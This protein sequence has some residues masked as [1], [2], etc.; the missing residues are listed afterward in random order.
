M[1]VAGEDVRLVP[2]HDALHVEG[3]AVHAELFEDAGFARGGAGVVVV[4]EPLEAVGWS[5]GSAGGE[6]RLAAVV[7]AGGGGEVGRGSKTD[8]LSSV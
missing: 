2:G 5:L 6:A 1:R 3:V 7:F 8:P 4:F